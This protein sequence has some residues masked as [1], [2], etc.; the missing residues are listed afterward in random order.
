MTT[1][2]R[3]ALQAHARDLSQQ[4]LNRMYENP[5]WME[6]Y[7]ARG[8]H[9]ADEDSLHHISYL[10]QALAHPDAMVFEKYAHW[11]QSV[12][13]S[14]G[15]CTEHLAENFRLLGDAIVSRG[16]PDAEAAV[17]ILHRGIAALRY[18]TGPA[19]ML[20]AHHDR[21]QQAVETAHGAAR[22]REDD[23]RYLVSYLIDAIA[24]SRPEPF[25]MFAGRCEPDVVA[26]LSRASA[27][28]G[29]PFPAAM[30]RPW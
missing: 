17:R 1:L 9:F 23:R 5:W 26:M 30:G 13:V 22:M 21:L 8:R 29:V 12:L 10:E 24:T 15:M 25:A 20:E 3:Q 7:G 4:V 18:R 14:R 19:A 16:L 28:I 27:E 2:L 6:R 11:L